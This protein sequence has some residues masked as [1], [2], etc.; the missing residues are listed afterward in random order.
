MGP[1][2][3]IFGYCERGLDPGLLAEPTN[4][5]TNAAFIIAGI[6]ALHLVRRL[7]PAR[8]HIVHWLLCLLVIAIG[9]GSFLFHS[10]ATR[11]AALADVIPIAL[12]ML[13]YFGAACVFFLR[14]GLWLTVLFLVGF[15]AM[16][17]G[18]GGL[19]GSLGLCLNGSERYLPALVA[20]LGIG[21]WLA[22]KRH[23]A[24]SSI[25][26]AGL[27]FAVSLT[28]RTLDRSICD[29]LTLGG[30]TLGSH[31]LWHLLNAVTLYLL[32]R[33]AIRHRPVMADRA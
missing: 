23:A 3:K 27:I 32:I 20:L 21:A 6:A 28:F 19:C 29:A 10:F 13:L 31:F 2:G 4:A 14:A 15:A 8:R 11:W 26:A 1:N 12:F 25:L 5:F 30:Y 18:A 24:A 22:S 17:S 33:A 16:L 9:I 7:P